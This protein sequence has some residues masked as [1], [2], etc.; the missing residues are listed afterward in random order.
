MLATVLDLLSKVPDAISTI[1][2][3][4]VVIGIL[5]IL[6]EAGHFLAARAVGARVEV[7]SV[8]FGKR[9][10]G[11]KRGDTDYRI[12]LV[13]VGGYVRIIGLGPDESDV[14][15]ESSEEEIEL[16]PKH[17]RALILLAGPLANII[18]AVIFYSL[19]FMVGIEVPAY[20]DEPPVAGYI[21][22]ES[23]ATAVDIQVGD[24]ITAV[25]GVKIDTWRDLEMQLMT[26]GD[27]EVA[28]E[29]VRDGKQLTSSLTPTSVGP[30]S[31]G[32]SGILPPLDSRIE[33]F[34]SGSRAKAAGMKVGDL[35]TAINGEPVEQYYDLVRLISP[36]PEEEITITFERDGARQELQVVPAKE[37]DVGKVGIM[38]SFPAA[39]KKLGLIDSF[40]AGGLESW[41]MTRETFRILGKMVTGRLSFRQVSGPIEI[42]RISGEVARSGWRRMIWFLGLISLQLGIFNLLPLPILDGG[43]LTV[44]GIETAIRRDF[45]IRLKE[46]ILEIGFYML[47]VLIVFVVANDIL[48]WIG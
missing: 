48:K 43:H 31:F 37:G 40:Q 33:G 26:S 12:S 5:V 19:A 47:L 2:A 23:P 6:H 17:Q 27:Q 16:L 35:I 9:L 39:V 24:L 22:P 8:G 7:F 36:H 1:L 42:A 14:V 30:Y 11:F 34:G 13:P 29:L 4:I 20:Q 45:S 44:I 46:K 21:I 28:V 3:F 32:Y 41:R 38:L 10:W 18:G 25:D 15:S